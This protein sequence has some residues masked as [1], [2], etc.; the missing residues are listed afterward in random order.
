MAPVLPS[1]NSGTITETSF[2]RYCNIKSQLKRKLVDRV[3]LAEV[4]D[5]EEE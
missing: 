5:D 1:K 2:L 3:N 4:T